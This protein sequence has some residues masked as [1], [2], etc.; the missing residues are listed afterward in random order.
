[1]SDIIIAID[2]HSATGKSST[3]KKVAKHL[4]YIYL[5][6]GAMYRATT[7]YF[8]NN[9]IILAS[10]DQIQKALN[11]IDIEFRKDKNGLPLTFLNG[12]NVEDKI[13]TMEISSKV[14]GVS[15]I[16]AVRVAMVEQQRKLGEH[17]GIVMDGRDIGS[18]VFPNA[19]LKIFM[20]ASANVRAERRQK[21]LAEK[22]QTVP[23][24]EILKNVV[25]RDEQ[26]ST[27]KESPLI[28][29]DDAIEIDNSNMSFEEQVN[30]IIEL[31]ESKI[32]A[33]V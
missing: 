21:E 32:T 4:G 18:V 29:V 13:R 24:K 15:A 22:G 8:L 2:G 14:S 20:T 23:F 10:I 6:S 5:D 30:Q 31:A 7:L 19:E 33:D 27:R 12:K 17:K 26:D 16:K 25:D 28:K 1:M 9:K 11:K 3:A